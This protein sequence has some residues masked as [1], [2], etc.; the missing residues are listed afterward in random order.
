MYDLELCW[1]LTGLYQSL[2][3]YDRF[4]RLMYGNEELVKDCL[5]YVVFEKHIVEEYAR[6][7]I[8]GKIIPPWL[9]KPDAILRTMKQ[10]PPPPPLSSSSKPNASSLSTGDEKGGDSNGASDVKSPQPALAWL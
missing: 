5:E 8:H 10:P 2:A 1:S 6:W 7:R 3:I 4:G 9:P